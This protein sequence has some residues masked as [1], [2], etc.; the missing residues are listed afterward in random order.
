[1]NFVIDQALRDHMQ[2]KHKNNIIV[3][4]IVAENSDIE[5]AEFHVHIADD[6]RSA[7]FKEKKRYRSFPIEGGEVL[8]PKFPLT[9]EDTIHFY[10]K[11]FWIF[12]S[13]GY[14]GIKL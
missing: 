2:Q 7:Y 8:L 1:M 6:K 12:K 11:Q 14:K 3:E 13:V 10:L 4:L 9:L 5:I